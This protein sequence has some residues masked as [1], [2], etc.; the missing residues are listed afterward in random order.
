[1]FIKT[2]HSKNSNNTKIL[3]KEA[4]QMSNEKTSAKV[5]TSISIFNSNVESP[6]GNLKFATEFCEK[7]AS[8]CLAS[9][10]SST[11]TF[12]LTRICLAHRQRER[13]TYD[14]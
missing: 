8:L 4:F 7:R 11:F 9:M 14:L 6:E 2:F 10:I 1:M 13:G 12:V 5:Y 3:Q